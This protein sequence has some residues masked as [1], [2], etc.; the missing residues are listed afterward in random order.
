MSL[1][2]SYGAD[3]RVVE[4]D[5]TVS[6][7][8]RWISGSWPWTNNLNEQGVYY[9]MQEYHRYA[10]KRYRYVGMTDSAKDSCVADMIALYTRQ[11]Y[12]QIWNESGGSWGNPE[13]SGCQLLATVTPVRNDDGSWDVEI[14]VNE[15]DVRYS[16]AHQK[17]DADELFSYEDARDYDD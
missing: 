1:R 5:L 15:D 16:R 13:D 2:T 14:D 3:N 6:Y 17:Y 7:S 11:T 4:T 8:R 10:R 12:M 9:S